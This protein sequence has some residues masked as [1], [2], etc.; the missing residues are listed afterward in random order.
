MIRMDT[1]SGIISI[2]TEV[3]KLKSKVRISRGKS[4]VQIE[5]GDEK[6]KPNL[7]P[8]NVT[9]A[10]LIGISRNIWDGLMRNS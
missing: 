1:V 5:Y 3:Q 8:Y 9:L 6:I 7:F 4:G 2:N 10:F